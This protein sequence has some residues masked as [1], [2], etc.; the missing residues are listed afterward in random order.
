M[1]KIRVIALSLAVIT[2]FCVIASTASAEGEINFKPELKNGKIYGIPP[3]T[4]VKTLQHA[5]YNYDVR[6]YDINGNSVSS[7][8]ESYIGSGYTV[9]INGISYV[10]VVFGDVDGDGEITP[11]DYNIVKRA[12]LELDSISYVGKIAAGVPE[13][14]E[15]RAI[16]YIKIKRAYFGT[17]DMNSAY[18]CDPYDPG[19]DESG[20]TSRWI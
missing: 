18:T 15:L 4:L 11:F 1:K 10:A 6:V 13:G 8:S 12:Y 16:N 3:K 19:A 5:Y 9:K 17:Y 7:S 2:V 20:W 14:D